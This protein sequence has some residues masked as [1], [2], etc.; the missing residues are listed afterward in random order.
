M[1]NC[2]LPLKNWGG[3]ELA[4]FED[5]LA[6]IGGAMSPGRLRMGGPECAVKLNRDVRGAGLLVAADWAWETPSGARESSSSRPASGGSHGA[7]SSTGLAGDLGEPTPLRDRFRPSR[8]KNPPPP[9]LVVTDAL[10]LTVLIPASS[11]LV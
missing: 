10:S 1:D 2:G 3:L 11:T 6:R 5:A 9:L 4:A 7:L 8:L